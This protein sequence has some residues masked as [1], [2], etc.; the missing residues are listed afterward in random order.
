MTRARTMNVRQARFTGLVLAVIA[1]LAAGLTVAGPPRAALAQEPDLVAIYQQQLDQRNAGDIEAAL[2][3]FTDDAVFANAIGKEAIRQRFETLL[4]DNTRVTTLS[5]EVVDGTVVTEWEVTSDCY[6]QTGLGVL[7]GSSTVQF[8]DDKI[9]SITTEPDFEALSEE[10]LQQLADGTACQDAKVQALPV[11]GITM[12]PAG[13]GD[14]PAAWWYVLAVSGALLT[15]VGLV[16]LRATRGRS[17]SL[18]RTALDTP[19]ASPPSAIR[20]KGHDR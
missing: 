13:G 5:A 2:T 18:S 17:R 15:L 1:L 8:A 11:A 7:P 10:Q 19:L 20:E 3:A 6:A 4:A 9:S 12:L 14:I 16:G